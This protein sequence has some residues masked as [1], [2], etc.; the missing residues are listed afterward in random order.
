MGMLASCSGGGGGSSFSM[1]CQGGGTIITTSDKP[2]LQACCG[3][4]GII[5]KAPGHEA[6]PDAPESNNTGSLFG[7]AANIATAAMAL[8]QAGQLAGDKPSATFE[9]PELVTSAAT[10]G[11]A[12]PVGNPGGGIA[13]QLGGTPPALGGSD[14]GEGAPTVP[15]AG[16]G[17]LGTASSSGGTSNAPATARLAM[18]PDLTPNLGARAYSGGRGGGMGGRGTS[19]KSV[20]G[21]DGGSMGSQG[22]Q[23]S[24]Y[25]QGRT[26]SSETLSIDDPEDYFGRIDAFTDIFKVVERRYRNK[27]VDW[28]KSRLQMQLR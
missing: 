20:F 4:N 16:G 9:S 2:E 15:K 12:T 13:G 25:G 19:G 27:A 7:G 21:S 10:V 1:L 14:G 18:V 17:G 6:C 8:E 28:E 3:S 22:T 5:F 23:M 24:E 11:G 26:P